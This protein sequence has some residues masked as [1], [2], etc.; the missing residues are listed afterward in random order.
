MVCCAGLMLLIAIRLIQSLQLRLEAIE[1]QGQWQ[2]QLPLLSLR[3]PELQ[4]D[5]QMQLWLSDQ[6]EE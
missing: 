4:L 6:A 5:A 1:Q 2:L 3:Q